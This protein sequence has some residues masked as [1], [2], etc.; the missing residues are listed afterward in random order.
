L[1]SKQ[2]EKGKRDEEEEEGEGEVKDEEA[3][4]ERGERLAE[5]TTVQCVGYELA[6]HTPIICQLIF[7][8]NRSHQKRCKECRGKHYAQHLKRLSLKKNLKK[9]GKQAQSDRYIQYYTES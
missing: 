9:R 3:E 2:E 5:H 8:P 4:E 7:A 6:D 1:H